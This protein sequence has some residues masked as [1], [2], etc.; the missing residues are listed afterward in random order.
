MEPQKFEKF[1][2]D[3]NA[4]GKLIREYSTTGIRI[5]KNIEEKKDYF[6]SL[7]KNQRIEMMNK[8][9]DFIALQNIMQNLKIYYA[10]FFDFVNESMND[11]T[12]K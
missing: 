5:M 9:P 2:S 1:Q 3:Y 8:D 4:Y 6:N 12:T 11:T 10:S 7:D